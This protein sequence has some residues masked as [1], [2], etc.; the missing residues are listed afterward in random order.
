MS[1]RPVELWRGLE[2]NGRFDASCG[3]ARRVRKH[4]SAGRWEIRRIPLIGAMF[5]PGAETIAV[6]AGTDPSFS[7]GCG[8]KGQFR[9]LVKPSKMLRVAPSMVTHSFPKQSRNTPPSGASK[10]KKFGRRSKFERSEYFFSSASEY[11]PKKRAA[12]S[13]L[14]RCSLVTRM[15]FFVCFCSKKLILVTRLHLD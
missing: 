7:G 10:E 2:A 8:A 4:G 14:S 3:S 6:L 12:C 15:S 11:C 1:R 5:S 13:S 9:A